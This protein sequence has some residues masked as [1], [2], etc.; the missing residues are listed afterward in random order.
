MYL[1]QITL[2]VKF[3]HYFGTALKY[4]CGDCTCWN[5]DRH[6]DLLK[7]RHKKEQNL[8]RLGR[9]IPPSPPPFPSKGLSINNLD[10][11]LSTSLYSL[12]TQD[13]RVGIFLCTDVTLNVWSLLLVFLSRYFELSGFTTWSAPPQAR[14]YGNVI[15]EPLL[16][17]SFMAVNIAL[18]HL[19]FIPPCQFSGSSTY[20]LTLKGKSLSIS[21]TKNGYGYGRGKILPQSFHPYSHIRTTQSSGSHGKL[22][23]VLIWNLTRENAYSYCNRSKI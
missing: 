6:A 16:W 17:I 11:E 23:L 2:D 3:W 14:K 5:S 9:Y 1:S 13:I 19:S 15:A 20:F 22:V 4:Q 10:A 8:F 7:L 12:W 21:Q 18:T